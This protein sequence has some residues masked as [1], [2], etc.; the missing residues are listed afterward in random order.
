MRV[1]G[2]GG[3]LSTPGG[4]SYLLLPCLPEPHQTGKVRPAGFD[5]RGCPVQTGLVQL[6]FCLELRV[7]SRVTFPPLFS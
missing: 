4:V 3:V 5:Q 7:T 1:V 6:G 2:G